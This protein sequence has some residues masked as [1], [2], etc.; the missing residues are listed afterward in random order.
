MEEL[1]TIRSVMFNKRHFFF[2]ENFEQ[3]IGFNES[4]IICLTPFTALYMGVSSE[5]ENNCRLNNQSDGH[6]KTNL[7]ERIDFLKEVSSAAK[8]TMIIATDKR[9]NYFKVHSYDS[10]GYYTSDEW[11][12]PPVNFNVYAW[13][14]FHTWTRLN[15]G[16]YAFYAREVRSKVKN[17][18]QKKLYDPINDFL[19]LNTLPLIEEFIDKKMDYPVTIYGKECSSPC[20]KQSTSYFWCADWTVDIYFWDYCSP[21]PG[22]TRYGEDCKTPCK[23]SGSYFWCKTAHSWDYCSPLPTFT[24]DMVRWPSVSAM[25]VNIED[26]QCRTACQKSG[27]NYYWC[28]I[29]GKKW[30]YCSPPSSSQKTYKGELCVDRCRI[31]WSLPRNNDSPLKFFCNTKSGWDH[32]SPSYRSDNSPMPFFPCVTQCFPHNGTC[33]NDA[34]DRWISCPNQNGTEFPYERWFNN[35]RNLLPGTLVNLDYEVGDFLRN[36]NDWFYA[37]SFI[38]NHLT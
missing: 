14:K 3:S 17:I 30:A 22:Q 4:V 9:L 7:E 29:D 27:E 12:V 18:I 23:S 5:I 16:R 24:A 37:Y 8:K 34:Q 35:D 26:G 32:C 15:I 2:I 11:G 13:S 10:G 25:A 19:K 33:F 36:D 20:I 38:K 21:A 28:Q 31:D 6:C 1:I